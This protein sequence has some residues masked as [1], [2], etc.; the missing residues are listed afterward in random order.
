MADLAINGGAPVRAEMLPYGRQSIDDEDVDAVVRVLRSDWLTT[1]PNVPAFEEAFASRTGAGY[2]VAVSNG[3]AA[4][5]TAIFAAGI[6]PGDE[7]IVTPM[8]FAASANCV[9]YQGGTVI[10]ADVCPNSLL[11]DPSE[12][13]AKI[14]PRTR[15][16]ISVDFAGNPGHYDELREIAERHDL[17]FIA[18]ACH[19]PGATYKERPV[20]SLG[21]MNVF[22]FHPVK[23]ITTGEGGMITTGDAGLAEKMRLFRNHGITSDHRQRERTGSW[24]YEM[25]SLGYNY[26]ITDIQC[27]LGITQLRKLTAWVSRRRGIASRYTRA[28]SSVPQVEPPLVMPDRD[29]S[30]HIYVI[31]LNLDR[32]TVGREQIF[33]ALRAENIG[34]NVHYLPVPWHPYYQNLGYAKG[35][36]PVAESAY[37]RILTLPIW[38]GMSDADVED[39]INAVKKV[40]SAYA[41]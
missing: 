33:K 30:W 2:A 24:H 40:V 26:R 34:V 31:H 21:D 11:L 14:T 17:V 13:Q 38:P 6:Q 23:H 16:I 18:D 39:V 41:R 12:V 27:A 22:S 37:E 36:W 4:L 1:G 8:T 10:F 9:R 7:V 35:Q 32:L 3:T 25:V 19:A 20:G 15:A 28:F 5:H 29:P